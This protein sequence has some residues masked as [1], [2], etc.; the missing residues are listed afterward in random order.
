MHPYILAFTLLLRTSKTSWE[1]FLIPIGRVTENLKVYKWVKR[2]K[3]GRR[4][5]LLA[6][7]IFD[8]SF[9]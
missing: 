3:N 7:I 6:K 8:N 1:K 9:R 2:I 5:P 4:G